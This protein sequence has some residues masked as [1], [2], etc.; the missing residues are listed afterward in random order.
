M[1][2]EAKGDDERHEPAEPVRYR[3][4][5][6]QTWDGRG[7]IP[8]WLQRAVNSALSVGHFAVQG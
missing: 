3:D 2:K 4:A 5:L 1:E 8:M 7:E 6:G